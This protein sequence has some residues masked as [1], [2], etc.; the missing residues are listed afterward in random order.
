MMKLGVRIMAK[1]YLENGMEAEVADYKV[2]QIEEYNNN[3]F[4]EALPP[5]LEKEEIIRKLSINQPFNINERDLDSSIRL[6][7]IKRLYKLFQVLPIHVKIWNT[8]DSLIRQGYI[9]RNP[10]DKEYVR[11][12]NEIGREIINN[13]FDLNS[14]TRYITTASCGLLIGFSGIGKTTTVNSVLKNIPQVLCH[15]EYRGEKFSQFQVTHIKLEAPHNASLKALTLQFFMK[16][17]ELL[18]TDN[19]KRYIS[20]TL[21]T[22]TML[23]LMG[24]LAKSI[25]LGLI[26]IDELQHL[27]RKGAN[28]IMNFLVCMINKFNLPFLFIGTSASLHIFNQELRIAR[29]ITGNGAIIWNNMD[30]DKEFRLLL[31]SMWKYQWTRKPVPLTEEMVNLFYYESQGVTDLVFKL[32]LNCQQYCI[33]SGKEEITKEI[34][35][36]IAKQEFKIMSPM[37]TAIRSGNIY[38]I[39][40][41]EDIRRIDDFIISKDI[42][43]KVIYNRTNQVTQNIVE[44]KPIKKA[45]KV[46]KID[47]LDDKDLRK[48]VHNGRLKG[49]NTYEILKENGFIDNMDY[50]K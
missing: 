8:I 33:S 18:G 24:N 37:I 25:G 22:D 10:F 15:S 32:F 7:V 14:S 47:E 9:S 40:Q 48:I 31:N 45:K 41:Y 27:N 6:H 3:P 23:M 42:S 5:I 30:N 17:D 36:K 12:C 49:I 50:F 28:Q 39:Q 13:T 38:K 35:A 4:L 26:V 16:V 44:T 11:Y 29:R 46:V 43:E 2:S 21:S 20:S 1:I 19:Y 34:V